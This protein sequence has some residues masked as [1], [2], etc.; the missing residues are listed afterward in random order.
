[1][2]RLKSLHRAWWVLLGL[3]LIQGGL[4]GIVVNCTGVIFSAILEDCGFRAGDLSLYYTIRSLAAVVSVAL[5]APWFFRIG[6]RKFTTCLAILLM[7]SFGSMCF[8]TELWHWY[9][10]AALIGLGTN[11]LMIIIPSVIN[12]WFYSH[13]G[14]LTGLTMSASGI[15]GALFSPVCSQLILTYHWRVTALITA[16]L[17]GG[18]VLIASRLLVIT[19]ESV[20]LTPWGTAPESAVSGQAVSDSAQPVPGW[21]F[22]SSLFVLIG[23]G[24]TVQ[25]S[26]QLPTFAR[27]IGYSLTVGALLTSLCMVG[28]VSGKLCVGAL[29]DRIGVYRA[30][31][32][33]LLLLSASFVGFLLAKG[34]VLILFLSALIFGI[35][36][37]LPTTLPSI[38]LLDL[39]GPNQYKSKLTRIQSFNG[40]LSAFSSSVFPYLYD[41]TGSFDIVFIIG[42]TACAI[43]MLLTWKLQRFARDR[44]SAREACASAL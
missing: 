28:N 19:P 12:N 2:S 27:S 35:V 1:M 33:V 8:Y 22:I 39:Y 17:G 38:L 30:L 41:L 16:L 23:A 25:L 5:V 9:L 3:L 32:I 44:T 24:A 11:C 34:T 21:V 4:M 42:L 20:G 37:S 26:N 29:C 13:K 10:S 14:L 15:F 18:L 31:K 7:I 6:A 36:Y 43:A 40:L